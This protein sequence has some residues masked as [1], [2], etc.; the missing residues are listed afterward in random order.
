MKKI[1]L[2]IPVFNEANCIEVFYRAV[3]LAISKNTE[4]NFHFLFVDDGSSDESFEIIS[5]MTRANQD[6]SCIKLTRNFGKEAAIIAALSSLNTDAAI[7]IDCDLQ[8]PPSLIENFIEQWKGGYLVVCGVRVTNDGSSMVRKIGSFIF[9]KLMN[10]VS[11]IALKKGVTDFCLIDRKVIQEII[12]FSESNRLFRGILHWMG[13]KTAYV[14]FHAP[15]R[16]G[17]SSSFY[18]RSLISLGINGITSFSLFPLRMI[19]WFGV[20]LS[21]ISGVLFLVML[22]D[23][24][25]FNYNHFAPISYVIVVNTFFIGLLGMSM[26]LM[27]IYIG[28]IYT[29]VRKRPLYIVEDQI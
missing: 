19:G 5:K 13:F 1:T 16:S 25:L 7:V 26:G 18:F 10:S 15:D 17:G 4:F 12:K 6:I 28:N 3:S 23:K 11:N 21:L 22:F 9:Y 29:D 14:D 24:F 20:V 2:V 27:A 8:H